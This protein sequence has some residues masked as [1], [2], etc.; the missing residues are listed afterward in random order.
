MVVFIFSVFDQKYSFWANLVKELKI[1]SL[2]WNF[3]PR[4]IQVHAEFNG[5]IHSFSFWPEILFLGK[6]GLESQ[7]YQFNLKFGAE[8]NS[9]MHNSMVMFIFLFFY[10]TWSKISKCSV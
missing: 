7:T 3:V 9:N 5:G 4:I 6:F 8:T 1:V 2:G 10:Q